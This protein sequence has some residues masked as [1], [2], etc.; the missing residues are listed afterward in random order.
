MPRTFRNKQPIEMPAFP[1][2]SPSL[3][4]SLHSF[5]ALLGACCCQLTLLL[6]LLLRVRDGVNKAT[7]PSHHSETNGGR[8]GRSCV[9]NIESVDRNT[10]DE[11]AR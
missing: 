5:A 9:V 7:L 1:L 8:Q 2:G 11:A 3:S 10:A 6:L 4:L